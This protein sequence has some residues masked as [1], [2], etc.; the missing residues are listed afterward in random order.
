M[1]GITV[2]FEDDKLLI[3]NKPA[4]LPVQDGAGVKVS[5]D[6]ILA[7]TYKSRPLLV[8]RLDKDTSG[9]IVTAKTRESAA[10]CSI[11]F[12]SHHKGLKKIYLACCAGKLDKKG[13][14]DET[15]YI[16]GRGQKARTSYI[17][18]DYAELP[19]SGGLS[20][21]ELEPETGRMHQIRRHL[22]QSGHPVLG[23]DKYGDFSLNKQLK[24]SLGI[25]RLLLHAFS[26]FLPPP[27]IKGGLL[28][29]APP[30]DYFLE[31]IENTGLSFSLKSAAR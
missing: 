20:L 12:T 19:V 28:I 11:F 16:K 3:L 30:P 8:H 9:V 4:G 5:L 7:R 24:K 2:L 15:L 25:K 31:L 23:D 26:I 10:A 18:L 6:S 21:A 17:R 14:I 27:L 13:I 1:K 29:S 22:A